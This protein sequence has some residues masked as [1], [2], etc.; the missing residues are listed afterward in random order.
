MYPIAVQLYSL[1]TLM[2]KGYEKQD[3]VQV[4]KWIAEI[5]YK[6]VEPAGFW[7]FTPKEF[8]KITDDLG[9]EICSSH[10][11]WFRDLKDAQSII[12]TAGELGLKTA[13]C[14]F[15]A[16]DFK[17]VESIK[18]TA[19]KVN[20]LQKA[21]A[22][23]GLTLFQHNHAWEFCMIDGRLAYD[24]YLEH[25]P[26]IKFEIDAYWSANHGANDPVAMTRKF[27]GR[28]IM[29]HIKDGIYME[30]INMLPLGSGKM[31]IPGVIAATDP[32]ANKWIIVELDNCAID[33]MI[34]IK[35]SYRY[36]VENKLGIGNK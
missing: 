14:G 24:I 26:D 34:G 15:G 25:C 5:G 27:R 22:H 16:D 28:C 3:F 11:P 19:E 23:G 6:G 35:S 20:S 31:D 21:A 8:K 2:Q 7:G 13:C 4:L 36:L 17:D 9:L 12:D 32:K 29:L 18:R 30:G 33:M 1:R 10:S